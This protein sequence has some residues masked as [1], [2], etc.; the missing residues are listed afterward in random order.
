MVVDDGSVLHDADAASRIC[1][2]TD[3]DDDDGTSSSSPVEVA[4]MSR[5]FYHDTEAVPIVEEEDDDDDDGFTYRCVM[6]DNTTT[7]LM[8]TRTVTQIDL[9][10]RAVALVVNATGVASDCLDALGGGLT[11]HQLR[12]VYSNF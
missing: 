2:T 1:A 8:T 3:D 4:I 6:G 10:V 11:T 5:D 9:S 12:W 7:I